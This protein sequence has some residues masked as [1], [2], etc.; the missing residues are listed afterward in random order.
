MSAPVVAPP[1]VGLNIK[2]PDLDSSASQKVLEVVPDIGPDGR[3]TEERGLQKVETPSQP[4]EPDYIEPE[5][6]PTPDQTHQEI[7]VEVRTESGVNRKRHR[8]SDKS[9][10][11]VDAKDKTMAITQPKPDKGTA[12]VTD[13]KV[14]DRVEIDSGMV[15]GASSDHVIDI[16]K[17]SKLTESV[18][19]APSEMGEFPEFQSRPLTETSFRDGTKMSYDTGRDTQRDARKES[20]FDNDR[21]SSKTPFSVTIER[22]P[23]HTAQ[24]RSHSDYYSKTPTINRYAHIATSLGQFYGL[25]QDPNT[26]EARFPSQMPRMRRPPKLVRLATV[27]M[28][29]K[30]KPMPKA[31]SLYYE[32]PKKPK[33]LITWDEA[34]ES[35]PPL[36]VDMEGPGPTRY[37]LTNRPLNETNSPAWTFGSRCFVEKSGGSRTSWEK[38]WFQTPEVWTS[39]VD[40]QND[41]A[42]PTPNNYKARPTLGPKQRT[43]AEYPSYSIGTRKELSLGKAGADKEP[44][45]VDYDKDTADKLVLRTAPSFTHQ[46]RREGT[47]IWQSK[48]RSPGPGTYS[49]NYSYNKT[50]TP[51]FTI[52]SL[53]REKSHVLGPFSTM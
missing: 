26:R 30:T 39:K 28:S 36:R 44:S 3:S 43:M 2:G 51:A 46:F 47:V 4:L 18:K 11:F 29:P 40:F 27:T 34:M 45:P 48:E 10:D 32:E 8:D 16:V 35:R 17:Q 5:R 19:Q 25:V 38:T 50:H 33:K 49:P 42:W 15:D 53:R 9:V 41:S 1:P 20:R 37:S 6:V 14:P 22:K 24:T 52:R 13:F 12:K 31:P 23:L 21:D 7:S